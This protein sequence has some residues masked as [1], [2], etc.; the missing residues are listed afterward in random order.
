MYDFFDRVR[1]SSYHIAN[2]HPME[3]QEQ[4]QIWIQRILAGDKRAFSGLVA[5]YGEYI[6]R[7][8]FRLLCDEEEARDAVQDTF[9]KVWGSLGRYDRQYRFSTWLYRIAMNVCY[10]RMRQ[11]ARSPERF[12]SGDSISDWEQPTVENAET[13]LLLKE[14]KEHI[15][16]YMQDLTPK[17]KIVFVL[18]D[19]EE[20]ELDE[21][22]RITGMTAA[23]IKS[24]LYLARKNIRERICEYE[25]R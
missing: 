4:I 12:C 20:M 24:N 1:F 10:D 19:V 11:N 16:R 7:L 6:Y 5:E 14:M 17:Q 2:E 15:F 9:V 3:T 23:K 21:I 18:R 22:V 25:K 8:A 13:Q